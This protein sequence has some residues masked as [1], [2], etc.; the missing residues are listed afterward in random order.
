M[1]T[2]PGGR[3]DRSQAR[4]AKI[5]VR[6]AEESDL[7][8][9]PA[10][11]G[12]LNPDD[13]PL[14]PASAAAVWAAMPDQ[15]GRTVPVAVVGEAVA[16]TA[17]CIVVPNLTR[18]GRAVLFAENLVVAAACRRRGVGRRLTGAGLRLGEAAGCYEVQLPAADDAYVHTFYF[19]E[20]CGL[21]GRAA[22]FR[23]SL[24]RPE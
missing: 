23:R 19:H 9:V 17:D 1:S 10:L 6:A 24:A 12:E 13:P 22:G 8:A 21:T 11:H 18:G 14:P 3:A 15:Q 4:R 5:T 7:P 16:G 20:A 2:A